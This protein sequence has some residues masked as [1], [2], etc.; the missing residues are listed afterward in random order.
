M[1]ADRLE[2]GREHRQ[3][4]CLGLCFRQRSFHILRRNAGS[5]HQC[6]AETG[7]VQRIT[8]I[9]PK[10]AAGT[11]QRADVRVVADVCLQEVEDILRVVIQDRRL[12]LNVRIGRGRV[13]GWR[14]VLGCRSTLPCVSTA[15]GVEF[16]IGPA[17]SVANAW[18]PVSN[19]KTLEFASDTVMLTLVQ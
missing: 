13:G 12:L 4:Q 6:H 11:A 3:K 2:A 10:R 5:A 14:P 16:E 18:A 19:C 7:D 17:F 9:G 15:A 8:G 1:V